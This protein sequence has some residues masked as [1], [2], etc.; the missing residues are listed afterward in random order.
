M[1]QDTPYLLLVVLM[2]AASGLLAARLG[3]VEKQLHDLLRRQALTQAAPTRKD[4]VEAVPEEEEIPPVVN[5]TAAKIDL[6]IETYD[7][8]E[9]EVTRV[10][11]RK[12]LAKYVPGDDEATMRRTPR[13]NY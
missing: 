5:A 13:Q 11:T 7:A 1:T 4:P 2:F 3:R 9:T 6:E 10:M 8:V 12:D